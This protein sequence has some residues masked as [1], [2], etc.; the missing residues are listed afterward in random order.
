M[1]IDI[2]GAGALGLLYGGKLLASGNQVRFWTRTTAQADLLSHNGVTIVEQDEEIH[3]LP[4][5]IQAKPIK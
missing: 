5:Q 2:V 1:I 3:I 4:D